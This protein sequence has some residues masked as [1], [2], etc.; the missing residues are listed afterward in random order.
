MGVE[1]AVAADGDAGC[2]H[3]LLMEREDEVD[4]E[5]TACLVQMDAWHNAPMHETEM[6]EGNRGKTSEDSKSVR[7]FFGPGG[8]RDENI[9]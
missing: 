9:Q 8:N 2:L 7:W 5:S 3:P 1:E 4:D 6:I